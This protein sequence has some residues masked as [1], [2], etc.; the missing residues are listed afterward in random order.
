MRILMILAGLLASTAA[1]A[2]AFQRALHY[3]LPAGGAFAVR[4]LCPAVGDLFLQAYVAGAPVG[5]FNGFC[6]NGR[7]GFSFTVPPGIATQN[8]DLSVGWDWPQNPNLKIR[9]ESDCAADATTTCTLAPIRDPNSG[10][11]TARASGRF[12]WPGDEDWYRF[13]ETSAF[14]SDFRTTT[15]RNTCVAVGR[16][17]V[18]PDSEISY[19]VVNGGPAGCSYSITASEHPKA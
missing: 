13:D 19:F 6:V 14:L 3:T 15:L 2:Q 16:V 11:V 8:V 4:A 12:T 10:D 1:H 7:A 18:L 5:F 17:V 9:L